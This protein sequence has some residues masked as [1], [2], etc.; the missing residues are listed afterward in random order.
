M[1]K[2]AT[3]ATEYNYTVNNVKLMTPDGK[4]S[5][6]YGNQRSDNGE[7]LGV[8]T[9]QY[10]ILQNGTL[11]DAAMDALSSRGLTDFERTTMV[12]EGGKRFFAEFTF[13]NKQLATKVGDVFGYRLTLQNS[14]DR[15]LRAAW[16]LGFLRLTCLN[17][18]STM[19]K[20]F[21]VTAKHSS[22]ISVSFLGDALDKAIVNGAYALAVY[23][24]LARVAI[25]DVQGGTI[26]TYLEKKGK[27]LSGSLRE[28][29]LVLWQNPKRQEDKARNLYNLYNAITE[30]MT[31]K[32]A[33]ERFEYANKVSALALSALVGAARNPARL[34][35]MVTPLP[36]DLAVT[37]T[38]TNK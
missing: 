16:Q 22:K 7:V 30:H 36:T 19:V 10:G 9:E 38:D 27:V 24:E 18:A 1:S 37:Q 11:M 26:L 28:D 35:E 17:G 33:A 21:N 14:F 23:D 32:V 15:S 20:E 5:G 13:K 8:T 12:T 34:V 31:H 2:K 6:F 29:I 3:Q 4:F 25:N